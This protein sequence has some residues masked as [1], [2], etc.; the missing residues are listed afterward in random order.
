MI[1]KWPAIVEYFTVF[2]VKRNASLMRSNAYKDIAKLLKQSTLKA[3]FQFIV[4]SFILFTRFTLK[5][6]LEEPLVHEILME[7]ELLVR[8]LA[9][10]ILKLK[11]LRN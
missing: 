6:Q 10:R 8:T 2:I 11:Q 4:D 3:E 1:E 7:L 9:G 5:F